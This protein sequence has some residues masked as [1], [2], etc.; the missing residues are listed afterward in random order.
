MRASPGV[1]CL[2]DH[3]L[4]AAGTVR[5][6]VHPSRPPDFDRDRIGCGS[7]CDLIGIVDLHGLC[8]RTPRCG[9]VDDKSVIGA[10]ARILAKSRS[11]FPSPAFRRRE[12]VRSLLLEYVARHDPQALGLPGVA[13]A[14]PFKEPAIRPA[15]P[16][17]DPLIALAL[18]SRMSGNLFLS[19]RYPSVHP[20]LTHKTPVAFFEVCIG[21]VEAP[22]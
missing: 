17:A 3:R 22:R 13:I 12:E 14:V 9:R 11:D 8:K 7:G 5:I 21:G 1:L 2:F 19:S 18:L 6:D 15:R 20:L 16:I 10:A 4:E